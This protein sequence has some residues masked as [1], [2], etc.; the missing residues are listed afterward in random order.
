MCVPLGA[1]S[2]TREMVHLSSVLGVFGVLFRKDPHP[3]STGLNPGVCEQLQVHLPK[4]LLFF[5]I[6]LEL[7]S[8]VCHRPPAP[9]SGQKASALSILLCCTLPVNVPPPPLGVR[10]GSRRK[11]LGGP[12]LLGNSSCRQ[13]GSLLGST[14]STLTATALIA[15]R[16]W[17]WKNKASKRK[18]RD[19]PTVRVCTW[20]QN[21]RENFLATPASFPRFGGCLP[22]DQDPE[23]MGLSLLFQRHIK[24]W[25]SL[26]PPW[27]FTSESSDRLV[28]VFWLGLMAALHFIP[29]WIPW[30]FTWCLRTLR[31]PSGFWY[32]D[33]TLLPWCSSA[34]IGHSR[35]KTWSWSSIL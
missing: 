19:F 23:D 2:G 34:R 11:G 20:S 33:N 30:L 25:S 26:Q 27:P 9:A 4:F 21:K 6:S 3:H 10:W 7:P 16:D 31:F 17:G 22:S 14:V 18:W 8:T 24:F 13:E 15:L 35:Q 5:V 32:H 29:N 1:I 12:S 28:H